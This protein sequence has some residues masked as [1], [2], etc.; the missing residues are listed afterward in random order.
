MNTTQTSLYNKDLRPLK[1]W[2]LFGCENGDLWVNIGSSV[3][4]AGL[5]QIKDHTSKVS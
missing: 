4:Y 3:V 1:K 5:W 2:S